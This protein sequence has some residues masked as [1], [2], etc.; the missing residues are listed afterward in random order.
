MNHR[1]PRA[2]RSK[3]L[4]PFTPHFAAHFTAR[5][6]PRL[7]AFLL[8]LRPDP[9]TVLSGVLIVTA[10][11][12]WD[13][14]P[15]IFIALLPWLVALRRSPSR[16]V[17]AI[18]GVWLS[19]LMTLGGF[20]WVAHALHEFGNIPEILAL[21]CLLLF[22]LGGQPQFIAFAA[23]FFSST[24]KKCSFTIGTDT[25]G[26]APSLWL[27]RVLLLTTLYVAIDFLSPKIFMDTFGHSLYLARNLRQ[28]AALGGPFLLTFL[29]VSVNLGL[30]AAL[31]SQ[32]GTLS[33]GKTFAQ[34]KSIL[35]GIAFLMSAVWTYGWIENLQLS[36]RLATPEKKVRVAAI[37][38]NIGDIEKIAAE[39]GLSNAATRIL[40]TYIQMSQEAMLATPKP[41]VLIWPETSFPGTFRTPHSFVD[42][43]LDQKVEEFVRSI[44]RP[45]FF[46][47]YDTAAGKDYNALYLLNPD[48]TQQTY[49]KNILLPFG[50]Y[51]P[52]TESIQ[53][54]RS[55]FPQVGFFGRGPGPQALP[56]FSQTA[57]GSVLTAPLICYEVLFPSFV[58]EGARQGSQFILNITNDSWFGPR[59]EPELHLALSAFR[60]IETRQPMIRAT[61]TGISALILP[62][63][64]ITQATRIGEKTIL[65]ADI[66]LLATGPT[67][68]Q[69]LDGYLGDW[70]GRL[71]VLV[72]LIT[73][74]WSFSPKERSKRDLFA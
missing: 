9:L 74:L 69:I 59:G 38:A 15:L 39:R 31:D 26:R 72:A 56:F 57:G 55:L 21:L 50:E 28:G 66:P 22:S 37:Q 44:E 42:R 23:L 71:S 18:Q 61:N 2:H 19:S 1:S 20:Y 45:L 11:P 8:T 40:D 47:G 60:S 65:A 46:G 32:R 34:S 51:I 29:T 6:S 25:Q 5:F 4:P 27:G 63:G 43:G 14:W 36:S 33:L 24:S 52:G 35:F 62:N 53:L 7:R 73:L 54:I 41:D 12:P 10:F 16:K 17:A 67:P 58:A 48:G 13:F 49:R 3:Q 30:F 64:E 70:V 68:Y